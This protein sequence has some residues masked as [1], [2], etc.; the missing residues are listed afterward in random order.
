MIKK[1]W[2]KDYVST[3]HTTT[4]IMEVYMTYFDLIKAD[5]V[6]LIERKHVM[7]LD[8]NQE[9]LMPIIFKLAKVVNFE[10]LYNKTLYNPISVKSIN[11]SPFSQHTELNKVAYDFFFYAITQQVLYEFITTFDPKCINST[12]VKDKINIF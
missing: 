12:I 1:E 3:D 5:I 8:V 4:E 9:H 6:D 2:L 11:E 10:D 7:L